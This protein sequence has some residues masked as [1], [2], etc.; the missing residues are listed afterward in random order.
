MLAAPS[1]YHSGWHLFI[2]PSISLPADKWSA[3][4]LDSPETRLVAGS[5]FVVL[6][7]EP[8]SDGRTHTNA[9]ITVTQAHTHRHLLKSDG[10]LVKP[11]GQSGH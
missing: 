6:G 8:E 4:L 11:V 7:S 2:P 1:N 3:A 5:D 10:S 9:Q